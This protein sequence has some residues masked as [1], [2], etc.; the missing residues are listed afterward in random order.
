MRNNECLHQLK[1]GAIIKWNN[2]ESGRGP[3]IPPKP[4]WFIIWYIP[5]S[6]DDNTKCI[7][8]RFT[9]KI[10][11]YNPHGERCENLHKVFRNPPFLFFDKECVLDFHESFYDE[12]S[13]D[14]IVKHDI[15]YKGTVPA[16]Q[17]GEI[18][19]K[20]LKGRYKIIYKRMIRN[21]LNS[22]GYTSLKKI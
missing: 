3:S 18:Y 21:S 6:G 5:I 12:F 16:N 4:F 13:F 11:K 22:N 20:L 8:Q 14:F 19:H 7:L 10:E 9:S 15:E 17:M 2:F 1:P